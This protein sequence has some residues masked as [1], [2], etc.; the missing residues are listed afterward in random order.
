MNFQEAVKYMRETGKSVCGFGREYKIIRTD[1]V[2][3]GSKLQHKICR[4]IFGQESI[5]MDTPICDLFILE[6]M[7]SYTY[8]PVIEYVSFVDAVKQIKENNKLKFVRKKEVDNKIDEYLLF[9]SESNIEIQDI[10]KYNATY[11]VL[12][13]PSIED[14]LAT[15][16]YVMEISDDRY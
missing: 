1:D 3:S 10:A 2:G 13:F 11:G 9:V 4:N 6:Q 7:L 15:D 14:I 16:W 8:E 12:M 5:W